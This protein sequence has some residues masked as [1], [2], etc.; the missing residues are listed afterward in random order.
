MLAGLNVLVA[1]FSFHFSLQE[2]ASLVFGPAPGTEM[3]KQFELSIELASRGAT[4]VLTCEHGFEGTYF[5]EGG[6]YQ[7]ERAVVVTD[8]ILSVVDGHVGRLRRTFDLLSAAYTLEN[9]ASRLREGDWSDAWESRGDLTGQVVLFSWDP[10]EQRYTAGFRGHTSESQGIEGLREDMDLRAVIP[11]VEVEIGEEWTI[12]SEV[13]GDLLFPGGCLE[14]APGERDPTLEEWASIHIAPVPGLPTDPASWLRDLSGD[15]T[16]V[17]SS[18]EQRGDDRLA[19]IG[20]EFGLWFRSDA[21]AWV[22][23]RLAEFAEVVTYERAE[24]CGKLAGRGKLRWDVDRGRF[25]DFEWEAELAIDYDLAYSYGWEAPQPER[26]DGEL[27]E[28]WRGNVRGRA[29]LPAPSER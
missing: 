9:G 4:V 12:G 28:E 1:V 13:V 29:S 24:L 14:I 2:D 23:G 11:G 22:R 7:V 21:L 19:V 16:A 8:E 5:K 3:T 26:F 27:M 15:A 17:L 25:R 18:I 20:I 10:D 6:S